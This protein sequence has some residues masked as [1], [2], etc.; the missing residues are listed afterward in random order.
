MN[1]NEI[2]KA[3][4]SNKNTTNFYL[5]LW[6]GD[7]IH[8]G[9]YPDNYKYNKNDLKE[10]KL[11]EIKTAI[12]NK[13]EYMYK[14]I[15]SYCQSSGHY[16]LADFGSG[17]GGTSRFLYDKLNLSK[18]K[19]DIDC[20]DISKDNCVINT[21]KNTMNNYEIPVYNISFL[22]IPF[23]KKYN[24]IYSEDAFIHINERSKLLNEINNK[25][26]LEGILIFSDIIL[27]DTYNK[28]EIQ[29]VYD[30]V[31]ITCLET[32]DSYIDKARE[33]N[34]QFVNSFGYK[35]SMLIHYKNIRDV[36]EETEENKE[37][38]KG[39]DNWIKHIELNNI[40]SKIFIFKKFN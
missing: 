3:Y 12:D 31:N 17:Y 13:K 33:N 30:R 19:F 38:I 20:F 5:K 25:L 39:L 34:L 18:N 24:I 15:N 26:L 28:S 40:T 11:K 22:E 7:S 32:H 37:I 10:T 4:Y 21:Y 9:I 29:E 35:E 36:V 2:T 14:F 23:S 27:T 6:G 16:Q 8:I 1:E